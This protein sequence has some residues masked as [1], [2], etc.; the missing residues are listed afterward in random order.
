MWHSVSGIQGSCAPAPTQRGTGVRN[1]AM[2]YTS[3][4]S[5]Q[6]IIRINYVIV[7]KLYLPSSIR[8]SNLLWHKLRI[9]LPAYLFHVYLPLGIISSSSHTNLPFH[10][11]E[12]QIANSDY[13]NRKYNPNHPIS[14]YLH[15]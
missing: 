10:A 7:P 13:P 15:F 6:K 8:L 1:G 3:K 14:K 5:H 11:L 2:N 9:F 12:Q 4:I